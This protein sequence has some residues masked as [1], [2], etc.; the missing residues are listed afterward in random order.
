MASQRSTNQQIASPL[1]IIR[2]LLRDQ[3]G[4]LA[5]AASRP[6]FE[7]EDERKLGSVLTRQ[8]RIRQGSQFPGTE[9][10]LYLITLL[11]GSVTKT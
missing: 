2:G 8:P 10:E 4:R 7:A 1:D 11:S 9:L 6:V 5:F 3:V